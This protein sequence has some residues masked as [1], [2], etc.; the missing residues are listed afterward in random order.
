[1]K[2]DSDQDADLVRI[3][4]KQRSELPEPT[5]ATNCSLND[6][7]LQFPMLPFDIGRSGHRDRFPA[8]TPDDQPGLV[9]LL[10]TSQLKAHRLQIAIPA[11]QGIPSSFDYLS[12]ET[13][14][15]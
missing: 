10:R 13:S 5:F 1:M 3:S 14:R 15:Q 8:P 7:A 12:Q 6:V 2:E 9:L 11:S 4:G